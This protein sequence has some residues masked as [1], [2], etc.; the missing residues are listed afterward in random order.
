VFRATL[1]PRLHSEG[2]DVT[3]DF[4]AIAS[5]TYYRPNLD[6]IVTWLRQ[7]LS[8]LIEG[9][10]FEQQ[11][12]LKRGLVSLGLGPLLHDLS[13]SDRQLQEQGGEVEVKVK[14]RREEDEQVLRLARVRLAS[15]VLGQYL[16]PG[17]R[18]AIVE[19]YE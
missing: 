1:L 7:R 14:V 13:V 2:V 16:E 3:F 5:E 9:E 4:T 15:D 11:P 12:S 17:T 10:T 18:E 19:S 8:L 6:G